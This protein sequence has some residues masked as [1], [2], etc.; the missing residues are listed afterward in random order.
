MDDTTPVTPADGRKHRGPGT[1]QIDKVKL[2]N[3][4]KEHERAAQDKARDDMRALIEMIFAGVAKLIPRI[5]VGLALLALIALA[6]LAVVHGV[7]IVVDG[8]GIKVATTATTTTTT[9]AGEPT[10]TTTGTST[11]TT[12][13]PAPEPTE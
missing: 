5:F 4:D 10:V 8:L 7:P 11:T 13:T 2:A 12:T 6:G 9:V 1:T 3:E